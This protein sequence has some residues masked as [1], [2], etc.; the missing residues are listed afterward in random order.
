M[1]TKTI[2]QEAERKMKNA[3]EA[4]RTEFKTLRTGRASIALLE[5]VRVSYYATETP[6]QQ[7]ANLSVTDAQ[8]LQVQ[9]W[10][11]SMIQEIDKAI[12]K[13]DLGL[14]PVSD[15]KI[16]RVPVPPLT[17]ERRREMVKKAH[18]MA[19]TSKTEIRKHRR[20]GNDEL[21][22]LGRDHKVSEDDERKNHDVLQKIHDRY[23]DEVSALVAAKE[24]EI[25]TI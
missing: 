1:D 8:T 24:K 14:N 12:R 2:Q 23:I 25:L 22:K 6:I 4:L 19:E 21:K 11:T 3:L 20:D 7:V 18:V 13:A 15:G 9:P 16:L 10:D 17:E 5:G